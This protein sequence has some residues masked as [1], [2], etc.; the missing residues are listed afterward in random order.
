MTNQVTDHGLIGET[1]AGIKETAGDAVVEVVADK[2][3]YEVNDIVGC[4]ENG[5]GILSAPGEAECI[6]GNCAHVSGI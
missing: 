6:W 4:L 2:G 5:C 3:Y 1:T